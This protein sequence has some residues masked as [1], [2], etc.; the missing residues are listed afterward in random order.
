MSK[1]ATCCG[2][3]GEHGEEHALPMAL[4]IRRSCPLLSTDV[5]RTAFCRY[6][7]NRF[8]GGRERAELGSKRRNPGTRQEHATGDVS[9]IRRRS[10]GE[11]VS[12][13][14]RPSR[15]CWDPPAG[16]PSFF[17]STQTQPGLEKLWRPEPRKGLK[18]SRTTHGKRSHPA[19]HRFC[20]GGGPKAQVSTPGRE[21]HGGSPAHMVSSPHC[22]IR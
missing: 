11:G 1:L 17:S 5:E 18:G 9:R 10:R 13:A 22:V 19:P 15:T 2:A 7:G 8:L 21:Q 16:R 12:N 20:R 6:S 4:Q 14:D 3:A